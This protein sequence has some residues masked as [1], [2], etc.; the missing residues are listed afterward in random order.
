MI[1]ATETGFYGDDSS[2]IDFSP[3]GRAWRL[4]TE[5]VLMEPRELGELPRGVESWRDLI[6]SDEAAERL[7]VD[8]PRLPRSARQQID[9]TLDRPG[10]E[11]LE[12][13]VDEQE[14]GLLPR[15]RLLHDLRHPLPRAVVLLLN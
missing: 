10:R 8:D 13:V 5:E 15:P 4:A 14:R 12:P 3:A 6:E 7:R 2:P 11:P 9:H 1:N